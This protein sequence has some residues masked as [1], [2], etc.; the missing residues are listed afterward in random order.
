MIFKLFCVS[1]QYAISIISF[2]F[3]CTLSTSEFIK[4]DL[5]VSFQQACHRAAYF[6]VLFHLCT[7]R[8]VTPVCQ[9]GVTFGEFVSNCCLKVLLRIS[10]NLFFLL[11]SKL[12]VKTQ[13]PQAVRS[14]IF[15]KIIQLSCYNMMPRCILGVGV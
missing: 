6:S 14:Q 2:E 11:F 7:L 15:S 3:N 8:P 1:H 9:Y 13:T 4:L 12:S 10:V 5:P